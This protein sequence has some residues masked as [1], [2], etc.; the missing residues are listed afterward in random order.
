[1]DLI[2]KYMNRNNINEELQFRVRQY[3]SYIMK[4]ENIH[5]IAEEQRSI[6]QL[7]PQLK[8]EL[9]IQT[10]GKIVNNCSIFVENFSEQ[11]L[12]KLVVSL[13]QNRYI[14]GDYIF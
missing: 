5:N 3:L 9:I 4:I 8:E 11:T 10:N 13:K 7:N 6:D 1:M 2:N 12:R 14:P